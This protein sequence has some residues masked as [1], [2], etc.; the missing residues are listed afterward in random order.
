MIQVRRAA[1][2]AA[3]AILTMPAV[4]LAHADVV[5]SVPADGSVLATPPAE[6][7]VTYSEGL[8]DGSSIVI[9]DAAGAAIATGTPATA[10][11]TE[12][13]A[14]LPILE[15][16]AYRIESTA[17]STDGDGEIKR[18][19]ITFTVAEP[20]AAPTPTAAP[21]A[22]PSPGA[23]APAPS[24]ATVEPTPSPTAAPGDGSTSSTDVLLP[25]VAVSAILAVAVVA[26]L[27][28]R[29]PA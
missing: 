17:I 18:A 23:S 27:R 22:E 29:G 6:V 15:P 2:A 8:A 5:G 16:G 14:T 13:R 1:A 28:R 20:A 3:V 25:I 26:L 24:T 7:V 12:M 10:G 21:S 4:V 9:R 19:V 11:A